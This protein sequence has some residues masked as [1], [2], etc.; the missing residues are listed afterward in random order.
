M[1]ETARRATSLCSRSRSRRWR[2]SS[3]PTITATTRPGF[4]DCSG[5]CGWAGGPLP[6]PVLLP[7]EAPLARGGIALFFDALGSRARLAVDVRTAVPERVE[8]FGPFAVTP[9]PARH[10]RSQSDPPGLLMEAYGLRIEAEGARIVVSGDTGF[11]ARLEREAEGADLALLEAGA[12][13]R[14]E[15]PADTH[16]T[17]AE[18]ERIGLLAREFRLYH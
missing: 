11:S 3:S 12:G 17:R 8:R 10:R 4:R 16:L 2:G 9:F 18:A 5:G 13:E 7:R 14:T 15:S 6:L 1:P